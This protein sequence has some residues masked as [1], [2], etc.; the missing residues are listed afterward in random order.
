MS[1]FIEHSDDWTH[2]P[3]VPPKLYKGWWVSNEDGEPMHGPFKA[4]ADAAEHLE[5]LNAEEKE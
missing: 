4:K 1:Y 2:A 3:P 5:E